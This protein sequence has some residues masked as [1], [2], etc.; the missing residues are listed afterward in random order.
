MMNDRLCHMMCFVK[1]V[2]KPRVC[3]D[4][5]MCEVNISVAGLRM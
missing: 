5:V 2:R 3:G 4:D 1:C